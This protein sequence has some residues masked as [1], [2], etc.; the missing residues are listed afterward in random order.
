MT[1]HDDAWQQSCCCSRDNQ[2]A[3]TWQI[4]YGLFPIHWGNNTASSV[5]H[6]RALCRFTL[7]LL[8]DECRR[9]LA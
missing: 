5:S 8:I 2:K 1:V 3:V 4:V 6:S 7:R 9:S